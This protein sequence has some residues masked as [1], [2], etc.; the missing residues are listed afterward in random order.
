MLLRRYSVGQG[1]CLSGRNKALTNLSASWQEAEPRV[2]PKPTQYHA[3]QMAE[4]RKMH[5]KTNKIYSKKP[6]YGPGE[7]LSPP[8]SG[9]GC[10]QLQE[11]QDDQWQHI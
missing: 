9:P 2:K 5:T 11:A 7:L 3:V 1:K 4:V 10:Q 6:C 8:C